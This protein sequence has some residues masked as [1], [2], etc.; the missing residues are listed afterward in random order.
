MPLP[1]LLPLHLTLQEAGHILQL[2]DAVLSVATVPFQKLES[3]QVLPAS[4]GS[5]EA[6]QR[7][8]YLLP[9]GHRGLGNCQLL[10]FFSP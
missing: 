10:G 5:I 4:V 3:L 1:S 9:V 8:I 7:G 6:L 2:W